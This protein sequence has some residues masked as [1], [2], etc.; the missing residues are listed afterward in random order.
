MCQPLVRD[1]RSQMNLDGA[2]IGILSLI[3]A[4]FGVVA[5]ILAPKLV[6]GA[7]LDFAVLGISSLRHRHQIGSLRI[8]VFDDGSEIEGNIYLISAIVTNCGSRDVSH[9]DFVDP[10]SISPNPGVEILSIESHSSPGVGEE[11]TIKDGLGLLSWRILK[12]K[13][14]VSLQVV[15]RTVRPLQRSGAYPIKA[16]IRLKDVKQGKSSLSRLKL[17]RLAVTTATIFLLTMSINVIPAFN[18]ALVVHEGA[19]KSRVRI[20]PN[21][22]DQCVLEDKFLYIN[23]CSSISIDHAETLLK[24]A[25]L[26]QSNL[27]VR[28]NYIWL[29]LGL[30]LAYGILLVY[31]LQLLGRTLS[32]F[33]RRSRAAF[34]S[35][36][37]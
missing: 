24:K 21:G 27:G 5:T 10:I 28:P 18:M 3:L 36:E 22:V 37:I 9:L 30:S 23:K 13:E 33:G 2:T 7:R 6:G 1:G 4:A 17:G 25:N 14:S 31:G 11:A 8:S 20:F 12:P 19:E 35:P 26:E 34:S 29:S 32:R 16:Q 15:A